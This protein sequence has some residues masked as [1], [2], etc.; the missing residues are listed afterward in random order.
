MAEGNIQ[1]IEVPQNIID[2]NLIR[3]ALDYSNN[4]VNPKTINKSVYSNFAN[5][6][7]Q[8]IEAKK[9]SLEFTKKKYEDRI[10]FIKGT[11]LSEPEKVKTLIALENNLINEIKLIN[12]QIENLIQSQ[13][14]KQKVYSNRENAEKYLKKKLAPLDNSLSLSKTTDS[15]LKVHS[16]TLNSTKNLA[17]FDKKY[18]IANLISVTS[19]ILTRINIKNYGIDND[20]SEIEEEINKIYSN[21][22]T[23]PEQSLMYLKRKINIIT[24]KINVRERALSKI[25]IITKTI[26]SMIL[27]AEGLVIALKAAVELLDLAPV[28]TTAGNKIQKTLYFVQDMLSYISMFL[29]VTDQIYG[30]LYDDLQYQKSRLN[31]LLLLFETSISTSI[32]STDPNSSIEL[33]SLSELFNTLNFDQFGKIL[34]SG[35]TYGLGYLNGFDY[36][37]FKFYLKEENNPNFVIRGYKRRYAVATN[38]SGKEII[39]SDYSFTLEPE[40][41]IDQMK[42][43]IDLK[44]L[45]A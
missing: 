15:I 42:I 45:S 7:K 34:N 31:N 40:V 44:N 21:E 8:E 4:K 33:N 9:K 1:Q 43:E 28:F 6:I 35:T 2:I 32:E 29:V 26:R 12:N 36:N 24:A 11:K 25:L 18:L 3:N 17:L 13:Q 19:L 41:L 27:I 37:G 16:M 22:V 20:I 38:T 10:K 39:Q 14:D 5:L 30:S 23:N